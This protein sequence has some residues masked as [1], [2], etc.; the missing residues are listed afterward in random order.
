MDPSELRNALADL[1]PSSFGWA[2]A[3]CRGDRELAQ[4]VL[5]SVY[6][7]L[8]EGKM[9]F[10]GHSS[11]RTWLF[12][13]IKNSSRDHLRGRWW[14]RFVQFDV[15]SANQLGSFANDTPSGD[16]SELIR[17]ALM[18]LP[19]RQREITHL[20]FYQQLTVSEAA[21]IMNLSIGSARKHYDRAKAKLRSRLVHLDP[22]VGDLGQPTTTQ[23]Q[24][25]SNV[26]LV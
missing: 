4:D 10:S 8:L 25:K 1:H 18:Q 9:T 26:R 11:F 19:T 22:K 21:Q 14:S 6:V 3:C 23:N 12:A 16:S 13:V 2:T 20:V 5:Q 17:K 15:A 24:K 7:K